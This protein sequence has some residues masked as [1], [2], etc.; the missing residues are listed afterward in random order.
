MGPYDWTKFRTSQ[1]YEDI[2]SRWNK[3]LADTSLKEGDYHNFLKSYPSIFFTTVESYIVISKLKL[4]SD[5]ETDF[6]I[7]T[8]GLQRRYKV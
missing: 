8:G 5:Y 3:L 6:V 7:S 2:L 4:G 1:I